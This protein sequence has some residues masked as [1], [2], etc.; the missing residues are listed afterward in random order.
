MTTLLAY[1]AS[2]DLPF[3]TERVR[4][5]LEETE[6]KKLDASVVL[7]PVLRAGMGMLDVMLSVFPSSSVGG[8]GRLNALALEV[9]RMMTGMPALGARLPSL[10]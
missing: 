3:R 2:R 5:P 4:T 9:R 6:V 10:L 8:K 1:D 7:V